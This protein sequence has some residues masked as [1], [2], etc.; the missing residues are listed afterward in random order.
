MSKRDRT[1]SGQG[2]TPR[3]SR[4]CRHRE[5]RCTCT[6]TF[7]A[8]VWDAQADKRIT[9]TFTTI[10]AARRWRQD[11]SVAL[12]V[13][14]LSADRGPTLEEAAE[15]WLGAARAGIVRNR[16]GETY[17]PS[18]LRGYD[19]NLDKR[20]LPELGHERLREITLPQ[21]QRLVDCLAAEGV[22]PA[23]ITTTI[24]PLRAIYRRARQLGEV[25][26]NLT[27]GVSVPAVNRRQTCFA[28]AEQVEAMLEHLEHA[29]NRALWAT[30]LYAGLRCGEL[31][32]LHRE[33][34]DLVTGIIRVERGWD[35]SEGE[36]AP[37]SSHGRRKVPIPAALRDRLAEYLIDAPPRGRSS[38][39]SLTATT[40]GAP[41]PAWRGW[42]TD[43]AR[44]P[45]RL[46]GADGRRRGERQ[47][48]LHLHGPCHIRITLDQ[49]G[50]LLP[51]AEDEAA[52]L[53][54]AFLARQLGGADLG[55]GAPRTAPHPPAKLVVER[56]R[57]HVLHLTRGSLAVADSAESRRPRRASTSVVTHG[58]A[59][60]HHL[61]RA[62]GPSPQTGVHRCGRSPC[63]R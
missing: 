27:S 52:D 3:H 39:V 21:L 7:K 32:A 9:Q 8:Q 6:P 34:V 13:G 19:Q 28:T 62:G 31:Q 60:T 2:I 26:A 48:P 24:T 40:G 30:T 50:H 37:K 4:G 63:A 41:P 61:G 59:C 15:D 51:G 43:P 49:Y 12:R 33:E 18:A 57:L 58:H 56:V 11:A 46:R 1:R 44:M 29:R 16:S 5:G 45:S 35:A 47:G 42:G 54:D 20:V 10:S 25:H 17:K 23:T 14:T 53:L 55:R 36:V 38:S 22:A